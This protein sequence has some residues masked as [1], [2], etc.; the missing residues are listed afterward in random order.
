[1]PAQEGSAKVIDKRSS[2]HCRQ[3]DNKTGLVESKMLAGL[4]APQLDST[5][6]YTGFVISRCV[7]R[8]WNPAAEIFF[9]ISSAII[10]ERWWP[11][12]HPIPIVR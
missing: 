9:R 3:K 8:A 11:P 4:P 1:M 10:T 7:T 5:L 6:S 12:V 2:S